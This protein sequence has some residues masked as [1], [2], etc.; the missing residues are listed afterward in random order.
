MNIKYFSSLLLVLLICIST[1][2]QSTDTAWKKIYRATPT[3]INDLVHT[4][5]DVKFD[6]NK[7]WMYGKEWVTLHP[8]FYPT[9]SLTLDAKGMT[10]IEVSIVKAGRNIPVKYVYDSSKLL[11]TLNKYYKATQQFTIYINYIVKP[12]YS[13]SPGTQGI[14]FINPKKEKKNEPVQ[15]WTQGE[16]EANSAWFATI[17]K[18]NQKSTEEINITA[19]AEY[20][21]M[22][23]GLLV[24]Q[25]TNGDGTRTDS[26]KT[27]EPNAPYLFFIGVGDY[28]IIKDKYKN[29]EVSY[30]VYKEF[31]FTAR[32]IFGVTPEEIA[33]FSKITG[34]DYPWEKYVQIVCKNPGGFSMENTSCTM[35]SEIVNADE[36]E[37]TEIN[38]FDQGIAHELFHQWFGDYVTCESWS[39]LTLNESF[40][41]YGETL[42][43]EY[44]HGKDDGEATT[45]ANLKTYLTSPDNAANSLVHFYYADNNLM[46]NIS[47]SKGG[48]ILNMLRNY[49]GDSAFFKSLNVYLT[50]HKYGNAE[51]QD[52]RLAFE[53][54]TGEDLNWFWNEWYYNSGHPKLDINYAYDA[55]VKTAKIFIKQTQ[56]GNIFQ[57]PFAI[58]VYEGTNK[59]RYKVWM[60]NQ[61]DTFSFPLNTKPLLINVD[62][63]KKLVCEKTDNKTLD[64]F[65]YQYK[66]AGNYIDRSEAIDFAATMQTNA[67]ALVFLRDALH[68]K[69]PKLK[70]YALSKLNMDNDTVRKAVNETVK[71]LTADANAYVR[72]DAINALNKNKNAE[73]KS[74]YIKA[75]TDSSYT[76]VSNALQALSKIDSTAAETEAKKLSAQPA[77][78]ALKY[79]LYAY[80]DESKFDSLAADFTNAEISNVKF[81]SLLPA[82]ANFL[83]RV[84]NT[85]TFKKGV[86]AI[87]NFRDTQAEQFKFFT[88]P[89]INNTLK[90]TADKEIANG[91][92]GQSD[93]I[94][95]KL[96][97]DKPK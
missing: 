94:L 1:Y 93:Y 10:I 91:F 48:C 30:Y 97:A 89:L 60:K 65:I 41:T 24:H 44:K 14:Y 38:W 8:H 52:L 84:K 11:I 79:T 27:N 77:R 17:D 76:V 59:K 36:R 86:D 71:N 67:E 88:D 13:K 28:T 16:P 40:A 69:S 90:E 51:A 70:S 6:Y 3:K 81:F 63:D 39:N 56:T 55:Q 58:D 4:R 18:P 50:K 43:N 46:D 34:V 33:F 57:F 45:Y 5:L 87:V 23:N 15:I 25:K 85:T 72:A 12:D 22:S 21:T 74:I 47:Y 2:S 92:K 37:L 62:A 42:W 82:F 26:W 53:Q 78:G 61:T 66:N 32:R 64:E 20:V 95:S 31:A 54:V 19:P 73:Y 7:S 35:H 75:L 83:V 80:T 68:D 96:P 29:K 49:V 9:D